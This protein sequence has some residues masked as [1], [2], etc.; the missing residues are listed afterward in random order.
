MEVAQ[1]IRKAF[2]RESFDVMVHD[3]PAATGV[4]IYGH[5]FFQNLENLQ[6]GIS[7][8][9]LPSPEMAA[10]LHRIIDKTRV[11]SFAVMSRIGDQSP[12]EILSVAQKWLEI[13]SAV[14]P[15]GSAGSV[16]TNNTFR[17]PPNTTLAE[18]ESDIYSGLAGFW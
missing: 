9:D 3:T 17:L 18:L 11:Q 14:M 10:N 13:I 16:F 2:P 1:T 8:T 15:T 5:E 12:N 6:V 4:D 7:S